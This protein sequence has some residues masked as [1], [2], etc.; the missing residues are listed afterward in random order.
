MLLSPLRNF[1]VGEHL[2]KWTTYSSREKG[3]ISASLG[4]GLPPAFVVITRSG[5]SKKA[6][7]Q[8]RQRHLSPLMHIHLGACTVCFLPRHFRA[9]T[10]AQPWKRRE[11]A[12][13]E[14]TEI[15]NRCRQ[16][17]TSQ[18]APKVSIL[19]LIP[20]LL[21]WGDNRAKICSLVLWRHVNTQPTCSVNHYHTGA[22]VIHIMKW[23]H[24]REWGSSFAMERY[25]HYC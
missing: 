25:I 19:Y 24:S 4:L 18:R 23:V 5:N 16:E 11:G 1:R 13:N 15:A 6:T 9:S 10:S 14:K 7:R 8:N 3:W 22:K 12:G 21:K 20:V 17:K 2:L